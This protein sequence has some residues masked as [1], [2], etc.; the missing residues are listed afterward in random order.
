MEERYSRER[1]KE[2]RDAK[3]RENTDGEIQSGYIRLQ[4]A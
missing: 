3:G 2:E 1:E 4:V